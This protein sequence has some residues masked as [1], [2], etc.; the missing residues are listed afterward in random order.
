MQAHPR[1]SASAC[2]VLVKCARNSELPPTAPLIGD[3]VQPCALKPAATMPAVTSSI[4]RWCTFASRTM[5]PLDTCSACKRSVFSEQ[6]HL[7]AGWHSTRHACGNAGIAILRVSV[8]RLGS[9]RLELRL[10][11]H[12]Q[13]CIRRHD[14]ANRR[15]HLA[16]PQQTS[17]TIL[18]ISSWKYP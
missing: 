7:P 4:T 11:Q 12:D 10:D 15:Q 13:P 18:N 17:V 16:T 8:A 6:P 3:S 1:P 14:G 9:A 5:P 2:G